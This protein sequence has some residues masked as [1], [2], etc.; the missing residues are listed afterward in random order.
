MTSKLVRELEDNNSH[1]R[2]G[3]LCYD[4]AIGVLGRT[5]FILLRWDKAVTRRTRV[6]FG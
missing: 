1:K 4:E 6:W 5:S 3:A 2:V